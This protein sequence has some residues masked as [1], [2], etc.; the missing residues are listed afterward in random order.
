MTLTKYIIQPTN[1]TNG[2]CHASDITGP[3]A[4]I[5]RQLRIKESTMDRAPFAPAA[6]IAAISSEVRAAVLCNGGGC[7]VLVAIWSVRCHSKKRTYG[8]LQQPDTQP[9]YP[10]LS[11]SYTTYTHSQKKNP[12]IPNLKINSRNDG[13]TLRSH[14]LQQHLCRTSVK[15]RRDGRHHRVYRPTR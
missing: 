9:A 6:S 12:P 11:S 1:K 3:F 7:G 2:K 8:D 14:P 15:T 10:S 5:V 4:Q 13:N